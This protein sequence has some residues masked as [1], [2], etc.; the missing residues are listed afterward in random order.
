MVTV[1]ES[2]HQRSR[3]LELL[4]AS[5]YDPTVNGGV[6]VFA[7]TAGKAA[8]DSAIPPVVRV[9]GEGYEPMDEVR[10]RLLFG[11]KRARLY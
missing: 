2:T 7:L 8:F 4:G 5:C 6:D 10:R 1:G 11:Y 3:A 9:L